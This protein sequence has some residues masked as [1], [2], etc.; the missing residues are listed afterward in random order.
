MAEDA[1]VD[2][3]IKIESIWVQTDFLNMGILNR[4]NGFM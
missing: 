3:R 4:D 2:F 1:Q